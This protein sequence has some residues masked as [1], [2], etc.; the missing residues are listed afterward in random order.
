MNTV[1]IIYTSD[2]GAGWSSWNTDVDPCDKELAAMIESGA[3]SKDIIALATEKWP[4]GFHDGL[5]NASVDWAE[6]DTVFIIDECDGRERIRYLS[7][8]GIRIAR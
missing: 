6:P 4:D 7:E 5:I 8:E 1:P 3:S 2:Y